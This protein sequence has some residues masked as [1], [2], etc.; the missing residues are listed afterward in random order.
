[1]ERPGVLPI[2][3][4]ASVAKGLSHQAEDLPPLP[5][6][7]L[8]QRFSHVGRAWTETVSAPAL[9]YKTATNGATSFKEVAQAAQEQGLPDLDHARHLFEVSEEVS[10]AII[11]KAVGRRVRD[12]ERPRF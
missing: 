10:A 6:P 5:K 7:T 3:A 1:M 8:R 2:K 12:L 11:A 4:L 9:S